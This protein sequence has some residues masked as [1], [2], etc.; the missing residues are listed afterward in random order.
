MDD[1]VSDVIDM[2]AL[3]AVVGRA[4]LFLNSNID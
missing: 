4:L 3:L 1:Q 2:S